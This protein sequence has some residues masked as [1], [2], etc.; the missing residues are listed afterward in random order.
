MSYPKKDYP[1][2]V[3]GLVQEGLGYSL[4]TF[5]VN[6][7]KRLRFVEKDPPELL[8]IV[9]RRLGMKCTNDVLHGYNS[10][11]IDSICFDDININEEKEENE[12]P[13]TKN[14][15]PRKSEKEL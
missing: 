14:R 4:C 10:F 6:D 9:S 3:Y 13:K 8:M 12:K 2:R 11:D 1:K 7:E 15:K 5:E